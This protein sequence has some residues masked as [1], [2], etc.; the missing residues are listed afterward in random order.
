[1]PY[2]VPDVLRTGTVRAPTF[3]HGFICLT[4]L[5]RI[6]S[7]FPVAASRKSSMETIGIVIG[8]GL[9][10]IVCAVAWLLGRQANAGVRR[11]REEHHDSF[12][13]RQTHE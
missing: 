10:P 11:F 1:M 5:T 7:N 6:Q 12:L 13:G 8:M 9:L 2:A 4:E 3:R